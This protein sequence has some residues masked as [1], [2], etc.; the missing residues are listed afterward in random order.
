MAVCQQSD[1]EGRMRRS[2][3]DD[4][5]EDARRLIASYQAELEGLLG[6]SIEQRSFTETKP[7]PLH[8]DR[9][10]VRRGPIVSV[11]SVTVMGTPLGPSNFVHRRDSVE[12]M[13]SAYTSGYGTGGN[14]EVVYVGGWDADA[15]APAKAAVVARVCRMMARHEEDDEGT[16]SSGVEGHTVQWM[17]DA[18]TEGE[19]R[20]VHSLGSPG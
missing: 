8:A 7:W 3:S 17:D 16:K 18:F 13:W 1:I 11:T 20:S 4:E 15:A 19:L 5:A 14:V 12:L 6:R 10:Y 2:L 9:F